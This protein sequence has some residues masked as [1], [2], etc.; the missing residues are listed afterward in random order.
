VEANVTKQEP[1]IS[2]FFGEIFHRNVKNVKK[3]VTYSFF[4]EKRNQIWKNIQFFLLHLQL[5]F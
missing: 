4:M 5:G 2:L 1:L 3:L